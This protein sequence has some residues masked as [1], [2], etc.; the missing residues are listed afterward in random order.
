MTQQ[1]NAAPNAGAK[2]L[3]RRKQ[4][5]DDRRVR[6][7]MA[8]FL[9]VVCWMIVTMV[10][11]PN[12]D[13]VVYGVPVNF[14]YDSA[15]YT[16]QGLSIV[17]NPEYTV[18]LKVVGNGYVIGDLTKDDFVVYPNYSSVKAGDAT[19]RLKVICTN[20]A[21]SNLTVTITPASTTV[22]V[23]FD[24]VEEKTVPIN[25]VTKDLHTADGYTLYKTTAAPGEVTLS[26]PT[27]ELETVTQAIAEV[28]TTQE[29]ND[30]V[31]LTS[32]LTFA[33]ADGNPV[34]FTY[35]TPEQDTV[36]VTLSVY[37]LAELPLTVN[38]I[39]EPD[40]FDA[41]VLK[42]SLS[43]N[44]LQVAGPANVIDTLT[45]ISI[46]SIDLSTFALDKVYDLQLQM[47]SGIVSQENLTSVTVSF[48]TSALTTKTLNL[49]AA[50]VQ[51]VNLPTTYKLT[52]KSTRILN[53]T[54]CG[55]ADVLS[56][57]TADSVVAQINAD[58]FSVAAGQQTIAVSIYV[59]A[60][61]QVFAIGTYTVLC[62]IESNT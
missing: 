22:S 25:V 14:T 38:F 49:D 10:I 12:T 53:V 39:N 19:L 48:D 27:S 1:N 11:Q 61:N 60:S 2:I 59:P 35:V 47:P 6:M 37:K 9:A 16:S 36:D 57:L 34:Q 18:S 46:G 43:Q 44:T 51:V 4:L 8:A 54:L 58:D 40:F 5:L 29:L 50:S 52:V 15:K 7:L 45:Q 62:Q 28:S 33:D 56:G 31:T 17:N 24:T 41:S 42:Y 13:K 26:G 21:A 32:D 23:R 30:T 3:H 55:P 20:E